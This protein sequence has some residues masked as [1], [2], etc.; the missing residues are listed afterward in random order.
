[1]IGISWPGDTRVEYQHGY[2][3]IMYVVLQLLPLLYG[4]DALMMQLGKDEFNS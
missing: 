1:V 4:D 3:Y 2:V